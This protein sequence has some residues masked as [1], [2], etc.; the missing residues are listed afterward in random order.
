[1]D[2]IEK[3]NA[4]GQ[5]IV[6][7][8]L[9]KKQAKF[10]RIKSCE[11]KIK[12]LAPRISELMDIANA[13]SANNIPIGKLYSQTIRYNAKFISEGI[14]HRLG[15]VIEYS[16]RSMHA[17]DPTGAKVIGFGIIGGGWYGG[18]LVIGKDGDII[19]GGLEFDESMIHLKDDEPYKYVELEKMERVIKGFDEFERRFF[20]YVDNL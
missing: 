3:I 17:M 6:N 14:D 13:L 9:A 5:K 1:M 10:N 16:P 18:N 12:S 11:E 4:I 7:A 8:E 19:K 15:F 20:E 2:R